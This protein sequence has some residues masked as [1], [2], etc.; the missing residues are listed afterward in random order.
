MAIAC[1]LPSVAQKSAPA[2]RATSVQIISVQG[3]PELRVD[4]HPF[5]VH[6]A[7][8]SYYRV[9]ADLWSH[10]LDRFHELGINT[11]DL[12]I[13]WNWHE[14]REGEFDFDGHTNPR[15]DLRGLL[16][17]ISD[18][19]FYLIARPGPAPADDWKND[20]YPGL[21]A[22]SPSQN[23]IT[24]AIEFVA[25]SGRARTGSLWFRESSRRAG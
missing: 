3:Y 9:P 16:K 19:G 24:R 18:K 25:R 8:F 20:G 22:R 10:S 2:R 6:A 23:Q 21:V 15:R 4:G 17:M 7:E 12:R 11:I 5:F 14:I 13:P 1:A